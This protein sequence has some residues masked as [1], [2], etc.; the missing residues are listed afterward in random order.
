MKKSGFL[1]LLVIPFI[2]VSCEDTNKPAQGS[3]DEIIIVADSSD[4]AVLKSSLDSTFEK[5]IFTPQ[6]EKLFNLKRVSLNDIESYQT[7]KNILFIAPQNS[8][9]KTANFLNALVDSDKIKNSASEQNS[10]Y[11]EYNLW[12]KDQLIVIITAPDIKQ[13]EAKI[14]QN[15]DHLLAAFRKISDKRLYQSLY[16]SKYEKRNTEG[17]LLKNYGWIIYVQSDYK[18]A[19][20]HPDEN[21]ICFKNSSSKDMEKWIFVYWIENA[22]PSYLNDDS[23]WAIRNRL[24]NKHYHIPGDTSCIKIAYNKCIYN[25][26]TFNGKYAMLSQGLWEN[27]NAM[28][29]PFINYTFFDEKTKRLYML[30][31]SVYAPNYYKRNLIQQM[32]VLLQSFKTKA[33]LSKDK[34]DELLGAA[35]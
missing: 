7:Y 32:D 8:T 12:A 35:E 1:L 27:S 34:Q 20:H 23:I 18:V 17:M 25:D 29:G 3:E 22:S 11:Q 13:I 24:T 15:K 33:E 30:D 2:L 16:D 14:M 26:V 21:F 10:F 6:P 4:F 9:S 28:E 31:G 19:I 5:I